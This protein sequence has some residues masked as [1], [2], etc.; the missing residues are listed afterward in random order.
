[1]RIGHVTPEAVYSVAINMRVRDREEFGA[2]A[3]FRTHGEMALHLRDTFGRRHGFIC[4]R[5]DDDTPVCIGGAV[6]HR[7][8]VATLGF[9][10][11]D[12]FPEVA[13][14]VTRF[15]K[16]HYIPSQIATGVHRIECVSLAAYPEMHRW[17]ET[18]GLSL[19][20]T[21]EAY[22]KDREDFVQYVQ[23]MEG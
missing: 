1:M 19:E 23:V 20:A 9:F 22:G 21:F 6:Q 17:L 7:P 5:A 12:R 8:G 4:V 10:A 2:V 15:V 14:G 18:L 13:V 16:R 3:A 11:T